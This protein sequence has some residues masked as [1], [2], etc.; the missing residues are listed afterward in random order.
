MSSSSA[1][2]EYVMPAADCP[3]ADTDAPLGTIGPVASCLRFANDGDAGAGGSDGGVRVPLAAMVIAGM[4]CS[5]CASGVVGVDASRAAAV[6]VGPV[7]SNFR[8]GIGEP[9]TAGERAQMSVKFR[10]GRAGGIANAGEPLGKV[11]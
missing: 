3:C 7:S 11:Q 6:V 9:C 8:C 4:R 2:S 10:G 1:C 5:R